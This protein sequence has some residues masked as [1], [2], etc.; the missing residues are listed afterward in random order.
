MRKYKRKTDKGKT[1]KDVME[2]AISAVT[3]EKSIRGVCK[4][5]QIPYKTLQRYVQ[6]QKNQQI[7]QQRVKHYTLHM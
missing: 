1:A 4:D 6:K 7:P 3:I 2:R 5:F